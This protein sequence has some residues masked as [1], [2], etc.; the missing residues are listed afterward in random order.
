MGSEPTEPLPEPS[1]SHKHRASSRFDG[2]DR[3]GTQ[4]SGR[5][6]RSQHPEDHRIKRAQGSTRGTK[7][8]REIDDGQQSGR[9]HELNTHRITT[10]NITKQNFP[11][12]SQSPFPPISFGP[13]SCLQ[14]EWNLILLYRARKRKKKKICA[15]SLPSP[16]FFCFCPFVPSLHASSL[17]SQISITTPPLPPPYSRQ[18]REC[19][20]DG[21]WLPT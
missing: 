10:S 15:A 18:P 21:W 6:P 16:P 8:C 13:K 5:E 7:R 14:G 11:Q 17:L 20:A 3:L 1:I 9:E 4:E 12:S 2:S 19:P